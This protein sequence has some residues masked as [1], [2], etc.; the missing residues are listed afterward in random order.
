M[1]PI[2]V[3]CRFDLC[4]AKR[5]AGWPDEVA[6]KSLKLY[7]NPFLSKTITVERRS[8]KIRATSTLSNQT[9]NR[10]K[11]AQSGHPG[12]QQKIG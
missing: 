6:K 9:P 3:L 11:F 12:G 10:R 4:L 7:L 2:F 5:A 8:P 1:N